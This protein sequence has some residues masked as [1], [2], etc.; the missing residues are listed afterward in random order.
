MKMITPRITKPLTARNVT[1]WLISYYS[2]TRGN[3]LS[4][5]WGFPYWV[6]NYSAIRMWVE[7]LMEQP[8]PPKRT[9]RDVRLQFE[10]RLPI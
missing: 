5:Y 2:I 8:R 6:D 4:L 1:I 3:D 10:N 9:L 7:N